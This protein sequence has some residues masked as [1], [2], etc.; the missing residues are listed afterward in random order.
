[1]SV[2]NG[3]GV[4]VV[5]KDQVKEF[6]SKPIDYK[7]YILNCLPAEQQ[8]ETRKKLNEMSPGI[9]RREIYEHDDGKLSAIFKLK[10]DH[11]TRKKVK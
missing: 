6:M 8:E 4:W 5:P 3:R 7:E 10:S 9:V 1:M 11:Y 2:K